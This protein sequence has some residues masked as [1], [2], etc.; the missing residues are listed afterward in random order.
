MAKM[1]Y[2]FYLKIKDLTVILVYAGFQLIENRH[3]QESRII[4][5]SASFVYISVNKKRV[6]V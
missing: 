1:F 3:K 2:I 6:R 5:Y 4:I